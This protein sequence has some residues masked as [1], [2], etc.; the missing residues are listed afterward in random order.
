MTETSRD[1]EEIATAFSLQNDH[2]S[3]GLHGQASLARSINEE[4]TM[5][6]GL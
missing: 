6:L 2:Q 3:L 1:F 4:P 5:G